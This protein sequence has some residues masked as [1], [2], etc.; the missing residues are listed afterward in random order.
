MK[1]VQCYEIFGGIAL[2][3][4]AFFT[5]HIQCTDTASSNSTL[6]PLVIVG[7]FHPPV[8]MCGDGRIYISSHISQEHHTLHTAASSLTVGRAFSVKPPANIENHVSVQAVPTCYS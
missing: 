4:H 2:K 1:G 3:N 7:L 5:L 8:V 6:Q